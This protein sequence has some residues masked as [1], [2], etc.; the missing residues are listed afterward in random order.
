MKQNDVVMQ[1]VR[2]SPDLARKW[3]SER[4]TYTKQRPLN[5][6]R[7]KYLA[8]LMIQ[9]RFREYTEISFVRAMHM[10]GRVFLVN[11]QH[12]L[13]AIV[14]SGKAADIIAIIRP[15]DSD[16]KLGEVFGTFDQPG[17]IRSARAMLANLGHEIGVS[18]R[19]SETLAG[20]AYLLKTGFA[21]AD[22]RNRD[23]AKQVEFR[24][25]QMRRDLA[26]E[27]AKEGRLY[28]EAVSFPGTAFN[29]GKGCI[30]DRRQDVC[31]V[32]IVTFRHQPDMAR[33]FWSGMA[34]DDGLQRVDPRKKTLE[35][36]RVNS[37][38]DNRHQERY[39][40]SGWNAFLRVVHLGG[41]HKQQKTG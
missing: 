32:G 38:S 15:V 1:K 33:D 27:W 31:A 36:L 5:P 13:S 22:D 34:R 11:G 23:V 20:A 12:T 37:A 29:H 25:S 17:T 7:V 24:D 4:N 19:Q 16:R 8:A 6:N 10:G 35:W 26:N 14:A 41:S 40:V 39:E 2:V 28:F 9:D 3:L 21:D 18:Q 30:L